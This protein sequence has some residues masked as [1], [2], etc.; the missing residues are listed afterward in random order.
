MKRTLQCAFAATAMLASSSAWA[1]DFGEKGTIAISAERL[2]G[3]SYDS[4]RVTQNGQDTKASITHFSLLSSPVSIGGTGGNAGVWAG[5]STPRVAGDYFIINRLSLGAA[6]GYAHW[7]AS[8]ETP[9][10]GG[11]ETTTTGDSF[12]FAPRVGY[13]LNFTDKIGFWPRGGLTYRSYSAENAGGHDLAFTLEAPFAFL[14]IPHVGFWAG[15]TLDLGVTGSQKFEAP[16]GTT[17]SYDFN[18]LAIGLQT[19]LFVYFGT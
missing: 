18:A 13:F 4:A 1:Q 6:I 10:P 14:L 7:S 8:V 15:P 11:E 17:T 3:F 9:G 2:F 5:Y 16:N 12:T 19:G